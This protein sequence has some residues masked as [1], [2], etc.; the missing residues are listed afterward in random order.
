[1]SMPLLTCIK[2]IS[3]RAPRL[4]HG[5]KARSRYFSETA[6]AA[7][8]EPKEPMIIPGASH[9]DLY[10]RL[11]LIPFDKLQAFFGSMLAEGACYGSSARAPVHRSLGPFFCSNRTGMAK[12]K[13]NDR[14]Q[15]YRS[16]NRPSQQGPAERFTG[17]RAPFAQ[18]LQKAG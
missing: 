2:E 5:E 16:G 11:D 18:T 10:D 14:R 3:P 9:V 12:P 15:L 8:A 7:V 6:Y 1:M 17:S 4:I 13:E